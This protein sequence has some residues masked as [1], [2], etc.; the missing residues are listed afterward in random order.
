MEEE[1][2]EEWETKRAERSWV[3]AVVKKGSVF[4]FVALFYR[5]QSELTRS[6]GLWL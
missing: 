2:E 5:I 6:R 3:V 1:E 4:V